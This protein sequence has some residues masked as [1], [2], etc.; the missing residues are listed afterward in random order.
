MNLKKEDKKLHFAVRF[1]CLTV[2]LCV[3]L[4]LLPACQ[5]SKSYVDNVSAH[6]V[7]EELLDELDHTD[8]FRLADAQYLN[9]YVSL[10][11]TVTDFEI[12]YSTNGNSLDEFGVFH[13]KSK[14][15]AEEV[16]ALLRSYLSESLTQNQA[17][18]DSYIPEE[19]PKLRDA[20]VRV[21]GNY[22]TYAILSPEHR[23]DAFD[24]VDDLL[25]AH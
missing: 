16:K 14:A 21:F 12:Y 19:T 17:F 3:A 1:A 20:E 15:D 4:V 11:T 5:R 10:P 9:G 6:A 13:A 2:F 18:Y 23:R 24:T 7:A 25:E 22:V 8:S